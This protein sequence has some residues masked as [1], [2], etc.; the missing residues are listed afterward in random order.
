MLLVI[1][2]RVRFVTCFELRN[3]CIFERGILIS[4]D[5]FIGRTFPALPA[6]EVAI[7]AVMLLFK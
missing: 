6:T 1:P 3:T 5:N 4:Q 2:V 7:S